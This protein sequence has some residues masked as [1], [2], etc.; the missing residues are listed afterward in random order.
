MEEG[1]SHMSLRA[2]PIALLSVFV[3]MSALVAAGCGSADDGGGGNSAGGSGGG[4]KKDVI[5]VSN[6]VVGNRRREEMICSI[7]AQSLASGNVSK[8]LVSNQ[9]GGPTEQIAAIRNLI[10]SGANAIIINPADA[11][12]LNNVI[13]DAKKRG[14][15]VVS[16]D[17]AVSSKDA[18]IVTND[19][20]KY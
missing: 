19:Q 7:K 6:T 13:A 8:V 12:A 20:V 9:N 10:S 16:V 3:G 11:N 1:A 17:Q 2:R 15:V 5:G 14:V 4:S 18:Y